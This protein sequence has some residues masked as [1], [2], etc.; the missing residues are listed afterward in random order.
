M[1]VKCEARMRQ[2]KRVLGL[3]CEE[4]SRESLSICLEGEEGIPDGPGNP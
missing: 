2:L 4:I 3:A 1:C